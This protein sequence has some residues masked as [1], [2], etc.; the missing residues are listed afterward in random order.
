MRTRP[1]PLAVALRT[2]LTA[3]IC[4]GLLVA[5]CGTSYVSTKSPDAHLISGHVAP[6]VRAA[7]IRALAQQK[8]VTESEEAGKIVA[9]LGKP[10][11]YARV[12]IEYSDTQYLIRYMNGS[13]ETKPGTDGDVLVEKRYAAVTKRLKDAVASELGRPARER[14]EAER[15]RR[16]YELL[17]QQ[18]QTAQAQANAQAAQAAPSPTPESAAGS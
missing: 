2:S 5:G 14:A 3:C 16:E 4:L 9:R 18:H 13:W 12:A 7:I 17:L 10:N 1:R 15:N 6:D 11:S 8:H